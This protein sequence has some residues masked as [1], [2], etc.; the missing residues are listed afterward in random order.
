MY[1]TTRL[2]KETYSIKTRNIIKTSNLL[3]NWEETHFKITIF[4]HRRWV[5]QVIAAAWNSRKSRRLRAK[6]LL[7]RYWIQKRVSRL[8]Q[9][10]ENTNSNTVVARNLRKIVYIWKTLTASSTA[11][12]TMR[13]ALSTA[14]YQW[15]HLTKF[16]SFPTK[17]AKAWLCRIALISMKESRN[18]PSSRIS[19]LRS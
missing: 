13:R 18:L 7:T 19:S 6:N 8:T 11:R 17:N 14:W 5:V 16:G 1:Q 15:D 12:P 4:H 3:H 9:R 2:L 10:P